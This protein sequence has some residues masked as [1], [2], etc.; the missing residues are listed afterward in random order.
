MSGLFDNKHIQIIAGEARK[1]FK[2]GN[3]SVWEK[4][5]TP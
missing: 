5:E 3:A 2:I 1:F 4:H